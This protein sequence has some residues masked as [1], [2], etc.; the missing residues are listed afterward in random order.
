MKQI[1][2]GPLVHW[3]VLIGAIVAGWLAGSARLHVTQFNLFLILVILGTV[4]GLLIVLV[5]TRPGMRITR[6]PIEESEE[7]DDLPKVPEG[8]A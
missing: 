1:F 8:A 5:T 6:D 4:L 2:L 3:L 7:D